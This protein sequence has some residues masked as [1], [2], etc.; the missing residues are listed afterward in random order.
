MTG[1]P[2][3]EGLTAEAVCKLNLETK[4]EI[5]V[6]I[7]AYRERRKYNY[8]ATLYPDKGPFRRESYAK[9]IEFFAAGKTHQERL[10]MSGNRC[11]KT[12][13]GAFE[14]N[15]HLT[16]DYP[17]WWPGRVF[18]HPVDFWAAGNTVLTTRDIVQLALLGPVN[19]KGSG[20]IP[21]DRILKTTPHPGA[22]AEAVDTA[23][24][25]HNSGGTSKLGFK[26]YAQG[27]KN[28]EGTAKHGIW[29]DEETPMDVY[30]EG[31]MR[32]I[33]TKGMCFTTFTPLQG[34]T[35]LVLSFLPHEYSFSEVA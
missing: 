3:V 7:E 32:I 33:T 2:K 10:N 4:R 30:G 17:E 20:M 16:G 11:G 34:L 5:L 9:H 31:L 22:V 28:F 35:E 29:Y 27:R 25:K 23:F 1:L 19:D 8:T 15:A 12:L 6:W 14:V 18:D 26:A 13:A 21:K 24:I